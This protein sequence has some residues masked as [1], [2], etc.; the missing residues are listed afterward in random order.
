MKLEL[1]VSFLSDDDSA[2]LMCFAS[3]SCRVGPLNKFPNN[4]YSAYFF[5][6]QVALHWVVY[7]ALLE[8]SFH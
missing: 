2:G 4:P 6:A 1:G 5:S 3:A 7:L 8:A